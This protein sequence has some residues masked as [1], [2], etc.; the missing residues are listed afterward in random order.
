MFQSGKNHSGQADPRQIGEEDMSTGK[1]EVKLEGT[2]PGVPVSG[3]IHVAGQHVGLLVFS[4]VMLLMS[5]M[6]LH[7]IE[8]QNER[9]EKV[10]DRNTEAYI[11]QSTVL[12]RTTEAIERMER[13]GR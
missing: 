1:D 8:A 12:T 11:Q 2:V 3:K 9:S 5:A 10:I 6:F 13:Q 7:F 4:V